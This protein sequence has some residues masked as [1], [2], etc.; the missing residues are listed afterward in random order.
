MQGLKRRIE[1]LERASTLQNLPP[2]FI[3]QI[4]EETPVEAIERVLAGREI[5]PGWRCVVAPRVVSP[6]E[7]C[8]LYSPDSSDLAPPAPA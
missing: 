5:P 6:E 2:W 3:Q 4:G 7:W 8:N 1:R